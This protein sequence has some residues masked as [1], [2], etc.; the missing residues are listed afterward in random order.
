MKTLENE[1]AK[2]KAKMMENIPKQKANDEKFKELRLN[3]IK[4]T[5]ERKAYEIEN[6]SLKLKINSLKEKNAIQHTKIESIKTNLDIEK[7]L[8]DHLLDSC[9]NHH[10]VQLDELKEEKTHLL[11]CLERKNKKINDFKKI[12]NLFPQKDIEEKKREIAIADDKIKQACKKSQRKELSLQTS[13]TNSKEKQITANISETTPE[14]NLNCS[15]EVLT[16]KSKQIAVDMPVKTSVHCPSKKSEVDVARKE[17]SLNLNNKNDKSYESSKQSHSKTDYSKASDKQVKKRNFSP[18]YTM[19]QTNGL[20]T[21]QK[22][23][24]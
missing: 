22:G 10:L 16:E 9:R 20:E 2:L 7:N 3:E 12:L 13:Q 24:F 6:K 1:A 17:V 19:V 14:T 21:P 4:L 8:T 15:P 23:N 5:E 11:N 18:S